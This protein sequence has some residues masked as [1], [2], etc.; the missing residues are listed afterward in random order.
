MRPR[1]RAAAAAVTIAVAALASAPGA[2]SAATPI[3][4]TA[5]PIAAELSTKA[6]TRVVLEN[7]TK[8][9]I[10]GLTLSV[11]PIEGVKV[12]V[13]GA[14]KGRVARRLPALAPGRTVRVKVRLQRSSAGP[15]SGALTV[16]VARKG[17]TVAS[18]RLPFGTGASP[19][20]APAPPNP[21]TLAGRYF[22]G[23][24]YTI[25]GIDQSS[26]YFTGDGFV[27]V[28][29]FEDAWPSCAAVSE[30]CRPYA[31]KGKTG[32]LT[33]DGRPARLDG[34]TLTF[35]EQT[36]SELGVPPA[37]AHWDTTVT[38]S[39]SSGLCPLMCSYYTEHLTFRPDGTFL[40]DAVSSGTGPV[41]DWAVVPDDQKGAYEVGA[42]RT[43]RL[44][45]ADGRVRIDTVAQYLA[46][47]GRL[48]PPGDGIV[49]DGDGYF[50]IRD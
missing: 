2:A 7:T 26:L 48:A 12:T 45:F 36:Y 6:T 31:Y 1:W 27:Y 23:S 20:P 43:L 29:R 49:L 34:R 10:G 17:R 50:D 39:N 9:R 47:D 37:G 3:R 15:R 42:D 30:S 41:A 24:Q 32:E 35:D 16:Q 13:A 38:Y 46:A 40:R 8:R 28:D 25:N 33:I 21:D 18:S 5:Q 11:A 19:A 4:V 14:R 44:A 22:W